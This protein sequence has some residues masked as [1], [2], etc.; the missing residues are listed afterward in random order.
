MQWFSYRS[1]KCKIVLWKCFNPRKCPFI[2]NIFL[3]FGEWSEGQAVILPGQI[4]HISFISM[5]DGLWNKSKGMHFSFLSLE[6]GKY[7]CFLRLQAHWT[8][9]RPQKPWFITAEESLGAKWGHGRESEKLQS[10]LHF[11]RESITLAISIP[12]YDSH[13]P[14]RSKMGLSHQGWAKP[15]PENFNQTWLLLTNSGFPNDSPRLTVFFH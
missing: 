11:L 13:Q 6:V 5:K 10:L 9:E 8:P 14:C 15:C 7:S 4:C 1:K 3:R 2:Q 12:A